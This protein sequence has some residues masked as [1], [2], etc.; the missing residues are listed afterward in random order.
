[1]TDTGPQTSFSTIPYQL[2]HGFYGR[3]DQLHKINEAFPD[4]SSREEIRT[5]ALW[6]AGGIGKSQIAL[7]YAHRRL[8]SGTPVVLWISSETEAEVAKSIREAA[9]KL[10]LEGYSEKNTLEENRHIVFQWLQTSKTE[11]LMILDNVENEG[12]FRANQP[13]FGQ[14][15]VLVTCRSELLAKSLAMFPL[16]VVPF[17]RHEGRAL[18]FKILGLQSASEE[19]TKEVLALVEEVG[20]LALAIDI[21]ANRIKTSPELLKIIGWFY[22]YKQNRQI[23]GQRWEQEIRHITYPKDL[24]TVWETEL[25]SINPETNRDA[26][27]DAVHLMELLSFIAPEPIPQSLFQL[28][29]IDGHLEDWQFLTESRRFEEAKLKL[30][31]LS[32]IR[33]DAE[34]GL[35][36]VHRPI[37]Q[38]YFDQMTNDSRL[39]AF[40]VSST[41]LRKAFPHWHDRTHLYKHWTTCERLHQH[42][43]SLHKIYTWMKAHRRPPQSSEYQTLIRDDIWYMLE[44]QQFTN[45][46][47]VMIDLLQDMDPRSLEYARWSRVVVDRVERVGCSARA[48]ECAKIEFNVVVNQNDPEE[49]D[50]SNAYGD[51]GYSLCSAFQPSKALEYLDTAIEM[52]LLHPEP[53]CYQKYNIDHV[54]RNRGRAKAQLKDFR[55][56]V[57]DFARAE[58]YQSKIHGENSHYD[59]ETKHERAKISA[60]DGKLEEAIALNEEARKLVS[61]GKPDHSSVSASH[62]RQGCVLLLSEK[63]DEALHELIQAKIICNA[64]SVHWSNMGELARIEWR[65]A[66]IYEHNGDMLLAES[67]RNRANSTK[68]YLLETGNH[69]KVEDEEDSWDSLVGLL[70]R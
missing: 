1:M 26:N 66:Q 52:A 67:F 70:Y 56:A 37:Q 50:L 40:N 16:E 24:N 45:A 5:V 29:K 61:K 10:Q 49:N 14:G 53:D 30:L 32:L 64:H 39:S 23:F 27:P 33:V 21:I 31:D 69:V 36:S 47:Y 13:K 15:D 42:V 22:R 4:Q 68:A 58:Y 20:G 25:A 18:M 43:Q 6:G 9:V 34:A 41:L 3:E 28:N 48:Q 60:L 59:G 11:W 38:A 55:G 54:F 57:D 63:Y 2:N 35:I 62:Y 44:I 17:S 51:M 19:E 12:V 7:E 46:R 65:M 8:G